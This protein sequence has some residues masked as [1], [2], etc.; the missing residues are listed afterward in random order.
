MANPSA[1]AYLCCR[2]ATWRTGDRQTRPRWT[3]EPPAKT[4]QSPRHCRTTGYRRPVC[5]RDGIKPHASC[6]VITAEIPRCGNAFDMARKMIRIQIARNVAECFH[7]D[8]HQF[9]DDPVVR[10]TQDT[11]DDPQHSGRD[12]GEEGTIS[13]LIAPTID[14]RAWVDCESYSIGRW[15]ISYP[16]GSPRT[17]S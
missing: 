5:K 10:Q 13:V 4:R 17:P 15:L 2:A 11:R 8:A 9:A 14:A 7:I 16:A 3:P 6:R 1:E 12:T